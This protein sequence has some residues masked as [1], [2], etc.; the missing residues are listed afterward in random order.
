MAQSYKMTMY[1]KTPEW[2]EYRQVEWGLGRNLFY[3]YDQDC[4][5]IY[6]CLDAKEKYVT[7][8]YYLKCSEGDFDFVRIIRGNEGI[9]IWA[10]SRYN[11]NYCLTNYNIC[12]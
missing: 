4:K 1:V 11:K 8:E 9:T 5:E 7:G 12:Q 3:I 6:V 2:C 10:S